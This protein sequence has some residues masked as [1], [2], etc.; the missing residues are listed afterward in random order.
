MRVKSHNVRN[1]C[2]ICALPHPPPKL[3]IPLIVYVSNRRIECLTLL[4]LHEHVIL[5]V[6]SRERRS[7]QSERIYLVRLNL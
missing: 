2:A 4:W 6:F 1:M 7:P 3:D 5:E